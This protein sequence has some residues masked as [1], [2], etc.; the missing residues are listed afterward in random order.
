MPSQRGG[1]GGGRQAAAQSRNVAEMTEA[2]SP[3]QMGAINEIANPPKP[4][5]AA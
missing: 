1:G 4:P 5:T 3:T 2:S